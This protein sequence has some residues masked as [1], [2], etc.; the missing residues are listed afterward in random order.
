MCEAHRALYTLRYIRTHH[1]LFI[2]IILRW[3][4][5]SWNSITAEML[6]KSCRKTG[7]SSSLDGTED[8]E[9]YDDLVADVHSDSSTDSDNVTV[10]DSMFDSDSE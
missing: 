6:A 5:V 2:I 8:G 10:P 4:F 9:L 7:I 1:Y 3:A